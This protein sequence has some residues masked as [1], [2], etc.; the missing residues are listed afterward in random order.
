MAKFTV[1]SKIENKV[2]TG[3]MADIAFLL[4][5]FFMATT[6][7]RIEEGLDVELPKASEG[8]RLPRQHLAHIW[9]DAVG[10]IAI[11]DAL[12]R[13]DQIREIMSRKADEDKQLVVAFNTDYRVPYRIMHDVMEALKET[14]ATNVAFNHDKRGG[15]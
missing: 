7:F 2:P 6:I 5:I 9:I 4:L 15:S 8:A 1:E 14:P 13:V 12:V 11:D 10:R 3:S